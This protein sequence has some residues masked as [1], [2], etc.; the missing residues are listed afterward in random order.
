M[1]SNT[2]AKRFGYENKL[3]ETLRLFHK[4]PFNPVI[5]FLFWWILITFSRNKFQTLQLATRRTASKNEVCATPNNQSAQ[6]GFAA[7]NDVFYTSRSVENTVNV[8]AAIYDPQVSNRTGNADFMNQAPWPVWHEIFTAQPTK[9]LTKGGVRRRRETSS[10]ARSNHSCVRN[11]LLEMVNG[12]LNWNWE[13]CLRS[14]AWVAAEGLDCQT[15]VIAVS[16]GLP[17]QMLGLWNSECCLRIRSVPQRKHR[18]S[19]LQR[20]TG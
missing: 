17:H 10:L 19:P 4:Q 8:V 2:C 18:T 1:T 11:P 5:L 7:P 6:R 16:G 14:R 9:R 20:S 3:Q 15:R 12:A 13:F